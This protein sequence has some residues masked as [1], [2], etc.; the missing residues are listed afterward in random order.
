MSFLY[1]IRMDTKR[2]LQSKITWL[3]ILISSLTP[4]A[5]YIF[6]KPSDRIMRNGAY[7]AN[8][9]LSCAIGGAFLFAILTLYELNRVHKFNAVSIINSILSPMRLNVIKMLSILISITLCGIFVTILYLPY[10]LYMVGSVF[11]LSMYL[12]CIW[13]IMI[14]A[15]YFGTLIAATGYHITQ[16][17]EISFVVIVIFAFLSCTGSMSRYYFLRWINPAI[18]MLSD[19]FGNRYIMMMVGYN[20]LFWLMI[21]SSLYMLSLLCIRR[22]KKGILGS[23]FINIKKVYVPFLIIILMLGGMILYQVQPFFDS[24][25]AVINNAAFDWITNCV[26]ISMDT[27]HAEVN[28]DVVTGHLSGKMTYQLKNSSGLSQECAIS[29]NSGYR[30]TSMIL[31][32]KPLK[33]KYLND[34]NM[35]IRHVK[36]ILPSE[37][38][39]ELVLTYRGFPKL[40]KGLEL[41]PGRTEISMGSI[42]L[43]NEE[44][45]PCIELPGNNKSIV[46]ITLPTGLYPVLNV[47]S[48]AIRKKNKNNTI[49]WRNTNNYNMW[50][51]Y[52]ANYVTHHIKAAGADIDFYYSKKHTAAMK[53]ANVDK[54]IQEVFEYCTKHYGAFPYISTNEPFRIVELSAQTGGGFAL[55]GMSVMDETSFSEVGLKDPLRGADGNEVMAHEIIHQWWGLGRMFPENDEGWSSEGLTVYTTYRMMKEKYGEKYAQE[56]YVDVWKKKVD[57]YYKD[58]YSRNPK[59]LD[60]LP[61]IYQSDILNSKEQVVKYCVMPLKILKAEKLVGGEKKMDLILKKLFQQPYNEKNPQFT[62]QDFLDYCDLD[63]EELDLD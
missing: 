13:I 59:Y 55:N 58:F 7:I 5:G 40:W 39:L 60:K 10:T 63:K 35:G 9:S 48:F 20:R 17:V 29:I 32:G 28:P 18:P 36:F 46:D 49:I 41:Y 62:Y 52:A 33:Y 3:I 11:S 57:S 23:L 15:M 47:G 24:G 56:H 1:Y 50:Q 38:K 54:A 4:I 43:Y 8:P 16:R 37:E 42:C 21:L 19:D 61:K 31:N 2:L 30:V 14:P 34:Y 22:F 51:L 12:E 44:F 53:T 27:V 6:Y 45:A 26:N 25:S